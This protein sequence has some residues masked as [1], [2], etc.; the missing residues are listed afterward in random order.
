MPK[1]LFR[2]LLIAEFLLAIQVLFTLWSQVGG[3]YH[4]D[5]MYWPWKLG[6]SLAA[7]SLIVAIT[8]CVATGSETA[9]SSLP[10]R[11]WL[12]GLLLAAT[13][14]LA[15]AVTYYYHSNEPSDEEQD[16]QDQPTLQQTHH[17]TRQ[18]FCPRTIG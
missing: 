17:H 3:Q 8:A 12:L 18:E 10:R 9:G 2:A 16:T 1:P 13:M 6:L 11:V 15:G 7:A 4:L 5:L 14:V